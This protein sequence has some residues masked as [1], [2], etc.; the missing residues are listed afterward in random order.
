M[1]RFDVE[2]EFDDAF[3]HDGVESQADGPPSDVHAFKLDVQLARIR[4][5][6]ITLLYGIKRPPKSSLV[7]V[8]DLE[9]QIKDWQES[10]PPS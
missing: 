6:T 3:W 5:R 9:E 1:D 8:G 10:I 2:L 7:I 4:A